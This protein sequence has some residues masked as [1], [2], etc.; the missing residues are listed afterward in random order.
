MRVWIE[1]RL[2]DD[3][4]CGFCHDA[5]LYCVAC[6]TLLGVKHDTAAIREAFPQ[7]DCEDQNA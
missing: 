5:H 1:R 3:C 7:H 6:G 4:R 2:R